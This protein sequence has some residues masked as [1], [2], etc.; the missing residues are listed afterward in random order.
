MEG[1]KDST[2]KKG[3]KSCLTSG[4]LDGVAA[5]RASPERKKKEQGKGRARTETGQCMLMCSLL[6]VKSEYFAAY[7]YLLCYIPLIFTILLYL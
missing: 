2:K 4:C 3:I 5:T 1:L 7:S 6:S